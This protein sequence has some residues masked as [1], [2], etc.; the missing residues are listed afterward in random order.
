MEIEKL[1]RQEMN[2][3][4]GIRNNVYPLYAPKDVKAPY[5]VYSKQSIN[6]LMSLNGKLGNVDAV[7]NVFIVA[8]TYTAL[9]DIVLA[10]ID[11]LFEL[12]MRRIGEQGPFIQQVQVQHLGDSFDYEADLLQAQLQVKIFY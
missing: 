9:Q 3:I 4:P 5:A 11:K 12:R 8:A 2:T 10:A 6:F 1:I 7:Y